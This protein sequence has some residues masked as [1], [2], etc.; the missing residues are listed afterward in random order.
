MRVSAVQRDQAL[1]ILVEDDGPG[2]PSDKRSAVL[3]RG[4]RLDATMPGS[5]LGL[6]IAQEIAEAY[7]GALTL[8]QS[9]LGGLQA[10]LRLP[11][12]EN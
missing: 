2:L 9:D 1:H 3:E 5:G 12:A 6:P 10:E 8:G 7:G 11:A 4:R